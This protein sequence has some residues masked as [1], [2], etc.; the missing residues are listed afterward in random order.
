MSG[1][2]AGPAGFARSLAGQQVCVTGLGVSGPPAARLLAGLGARVTVLDSGTGPDAAALADGLAESGV[3]V[4]LGQAQ[5]P[6]RDHP[7]RHQPGGHDAGLAAG[8]AAARR[9]GQGGHPGDR[10]R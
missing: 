1:A 5:A 8:H 9:G 2:A 6:G 4:L 10:R 3:R 7:G